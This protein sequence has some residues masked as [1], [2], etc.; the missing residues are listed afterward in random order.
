MVVKG[1]Y[2]SKVIS[3][4]QAAEYLNEGYF[5]ADLHCHTSFS[6]DVPDVPETS[7]EHV[8]KEQLW[9]GLR[10]VISDHD[11]LNGYNHFMNN[12][13]IS[14]ARKAL[15]IP[16]VE[17]TI[18]PVKANLVD[19]K[20]RMHTVHI[21]V[22]GLDDKDLSILE[23]IAKSGDLD[24]FI[25][26]LKD[27]NLD[28]MYNHPFWHET[29]EKLNWKVIP[30][31]AKNYFDVIELN[32]GRSRAMN[33]L[34]VHMAEQFGKGIVA[35]SDSHIGRPGKAFVLAKGENFKEFWN[36]IKRGEMF[37]VRHDMTTF[38]VVKE[39]R[40]AITQ[41]FDAD[42]NTT[43]DKVFVPSLGIKI[44]DK[45]AHTVTNGSL[46]NQHIIKKIIST[47]LHTLNFSAGPLIAWKFYISKQNDFAE[48]FRNRIVKATRD[49]DVQYRTMKHGKKIPSRHV[50]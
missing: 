3:V 38:G 13:R 42:T 28:Y 6:Y 17:I 26:Y 41:I 31:L 29:G 7:P 24:I 45:I 49:I 2:G 21:N 19:L 40:V 30:G 27:N 12:K 10:P 35:S 47:I 32:A 39:T 48:K 16:A 1:K 44:I 20:K 23:N 8:I 46:K 33:D 9:Q 37:I 11:T 43:E 4:E 18:K 15:L 36:N 34:A 22:F 25:K 14:D 50:M 5:A